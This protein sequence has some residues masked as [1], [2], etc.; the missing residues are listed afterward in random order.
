MTILHKRALLLAKV[1]S[2]FRTD[3]VPTAALD[4]FLVNSPDFVP[5]ITAITR[6]N[7]KTDISPDA[8]RAGRKIAKVSF[9]HE[10]RGEGSIASAPRLGRLFRGCG[11]SETQRAATADDT[12]IEGGGAGPS[13]YVPLDIKTGGSTG[14][15]TFAKTTAYSG[16]VRR[17]I[18]LTCTTGGASGVAEFAVTAPARGALAAISDTGQVMTDAT[19]FALG[20]GL[21]AEITPTVGTSFAASDQFQ[22][23][24]VPEGWEYDPV[25]GNFDSLTLYLYFGE[26]GATGL[27]HKLTGARGTWSVEGNGGEIA[28]LNF[29]FTG[30]WNDP[31]DATVPS[32]P[33][34][35]YDFTPPLVELADL[36]VS[37]AATADAEDDGYVGNGNDLV[38]SLCA[39]TFGVDLAGDVQVRECINGPQA[40]EGG[41][42]VGRAPVMTFNPETVIEATY[43]FWAKLSAAAGVQA[44]VDV[45][46]ATGNIVNFFAPNAQ[47]TGLSYAERNGLR[48]YEATLN[49]A[50][51]NGNDELKVAFR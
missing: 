12:I 4:A 2:V 51:I 45:G 24:L 31:A 28:L 11:M 6:E 19:A 39:Q 43:P 21:A 47:F 5:D 3:A 44:N 35:S 50:R 49:L 7:V 41:L 13:S 38:S 22:I 14:D 40:Y 42:F 20:T 15:F 23:D 37:S 46:T 30:D 34:L 8:S 17:T 10:V 29:E 36:F 1:E 48:T 32:N 27:L 16:T 9:T 26:P 25:S 33:V 18:T